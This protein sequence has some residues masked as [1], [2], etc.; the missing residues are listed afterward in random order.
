MKKK[1][2][3]ESLSTRDKYLKKFK[4]LQA[5]VREKMKKI[6]DPANRATA[7][8]L[9][10]VEGRSERPLWSDVRLRWQAANE[11]VTAMLAYYASNPDLHFYMVTFIDDCGLT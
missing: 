4:S 10:G 6:P 11:F 8:A 9:V 5:L 2:P 7:L 3:T 1:I